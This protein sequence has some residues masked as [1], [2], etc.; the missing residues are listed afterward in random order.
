MKYQATLRLMAIIALPLLAACQDHH[1]VPYDKMKPLEAPKPMTEEQ[2]KAAAEQARQSAQQAPQAPLAPMQQAPQASQAPQAPAQQGYGAPPVAMEAVTI[3]S[4][5]VELSASVGKPEPGWA[6]YVVVRPPEGGPPLAAKR[7]D[8]VSFPVEF[9]VTTRDA[10]MGEV[11]PG[12]PVSV[13]A[14]YDSDGDP[15]SKDPKD[16]FGKGKETVKAGSG[17]TVIVLGK[18]GK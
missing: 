3:V 2:K 4:G 11:K 9:A 1:F 14:V 10:M 18:R 5:R 12:M 13:E 7:L 6:L 17:K 16:L 15:I 8:K